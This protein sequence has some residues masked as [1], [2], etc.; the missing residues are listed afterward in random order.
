MQKPENEESWYMVMDH[1]ISGCEEEST[2]GE[3]EDDDDGEDGPKGIVANLFE[4]LL[5]QHTERNERE[6]ERNLG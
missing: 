6:R 3:L 2:D 5:Q 4:D 1:G